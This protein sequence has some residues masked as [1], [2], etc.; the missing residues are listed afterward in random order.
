MT[1]EEPI[2]F[3]IVGSG[4]RSEFFLR[5][6]QALPER[7]EITGLVTRNLETARAVTE[8]WGVPTHAD[9]ADLVSA[10]HPEFV[11]VS[12]PREVAPETIERLVELR[13]PVL[14]ETPPALDL[15]GMTTL[16]ER[17]AHR[18]IVQIA[19]QYHLSP[20]LNAQLAIARSGRIGTVSQALVAQCHDYHGVSVMRRALGIG[21]E[22]ATITASVFRYPMLNG[23]GRGGDPEVE[24]F[25]TATQTTGRFDFG[26][27]LGVYDFAPEQYFSWIRGNRLLVRGDRGEIDDLEVRYAKDLAPVF[28]RIRRSMAGEGGNLEG[29]FLRGLLLGEE[30]VF[31]NPFRPG[32]LADDEIAIALLLA[33]MRTRIAG[34]AEVY[35]LAEASQDHYLALLMQQAEQS[36]EPVRSARQVWADDV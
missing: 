9:V 28:A 4:W 3:G 30:W 18:G 20:L 14:C 1:A 33:G 11:V 7:F 35:S 21:A 26:D 31:T 10:R 34:G 19:E 2:R 13:M 36:G 27:R 15:D 6:A 17:V 16:Y 24:E 29:L 8:R 5:I 32:R 22:D 25:V 12:V 23:P